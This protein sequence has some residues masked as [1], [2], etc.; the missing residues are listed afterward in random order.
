MTPVPCHPSRHGLPTRGIKTGREMSART[1]GA[2]V[3]IPPQRRNFVRPSGFGNPDPASLFQFPVNPQGCPVSPANHGQPTQ[4][5]RECDKR[6]HRSI[7]VH[8]SRPCHYC[9]ATRPGLQLTFPGPNG[10]KPP[11]Q[12]PNLAQIARLSSAEITS[13]GR[14]GTP[15][16]EASVP[17]DRRPRRPDS[18]PVAGAITGVSTL[19]P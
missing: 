4:G 5:T 16:S 6:R 3:G 17:A 14:P 19:S 10:A 7:L 18:I 13:S 15:S 1:I 8:S 12:N 9:C 11:V 2:G